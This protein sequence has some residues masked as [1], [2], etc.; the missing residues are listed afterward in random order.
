LSTP[1][2]SNT[3]ATRLILS[4]LQCWLAEKSAHRLKIL[5]G[6]LEALTVLL[7]GFG[8]FDV[9]VRLCGCG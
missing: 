7:V 9:Y 3:E 6:W 2:Y 1:P 4:T 8:L 5:T